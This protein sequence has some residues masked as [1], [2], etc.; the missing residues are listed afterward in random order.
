MSIIG[1]AYVLRAISRTR[2]FELL[3]H[4]NL[5]AAEQAQIIAEWDVEREIRDRPLTES[6]YR[7]YLT[8]KI[9][10][11]DGWLSAGDITEE[12]RGIMLADLIEEYS[13]NL[14]GLGYTEKAI[15]ILVFLA[16]PEGR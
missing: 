3:G 11:I 8:T 6:Q 1:K 13:E 12:K 4:L 14:R 10:Q 16:V 7:K 15:G 5:A 9:K 2:V